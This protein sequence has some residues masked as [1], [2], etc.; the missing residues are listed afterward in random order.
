MYFKIGE[1]VNV[2]KV[3]NVIKFGPKC[4]RPFGWS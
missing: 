2:I 1:V 4:N 3:L